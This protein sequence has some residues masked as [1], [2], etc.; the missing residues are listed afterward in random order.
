[1]TV[2]KY[3]YAAMCQNGSDNTKILLHKMQVSNLKRMPDPLIADYFQLT[4][5]Q[6][7]QCRAV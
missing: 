4:F 3:M 2:G 1:M 7:P 6:R 5:P